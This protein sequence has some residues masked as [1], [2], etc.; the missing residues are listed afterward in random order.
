[1]AGTQVIRKYDSFGFC[2]AGFAL[3]MSAGLESDDLGQT[4]HF[5]DAHFD[6]VSSESRKVIIVSETMPPGYTSFS[7]LL[8]W[9]KLKRGG[10][11]LEDSGFGLN[12][13]GYAAS[14]STLLPWFKLKSEGLDS[15]S[16]LEA[17]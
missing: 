14:F 16:E 15:D 1:M 8:P 4:F 5:F 12:P 3:N 6:G 13:A 10:L 7:T 17:A 9:L 2:V 11:L